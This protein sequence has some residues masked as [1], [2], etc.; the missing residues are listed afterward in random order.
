MPPTL[1]ISSGLALCLALAACS[2]PPPPPPS[3]PTVNS[4]A[5]AALAGEVM[6]GIVGHAG[7]MAQQ[8]AMAAEDFAYMLLEKPGAYIFL[9][10]GDVNG[11][12]RAQGHGLGPCT[13]HN[14]SY[15][16][17]DDLIPIGAAFWQLLVKRFLAA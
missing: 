13:L 8:P 9:G 6:A 1:K 10:N 3:G 12:H 16:F 2:E 5:E 4:A 17:N 15:D 7:V 14:P 11:L